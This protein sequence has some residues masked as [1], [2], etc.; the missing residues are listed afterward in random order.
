MTNAETVLLRQLKPLFVNAI[1]D[2]IVIALRRPEESLCFSQPENGQ[3]QFFP[4]R[5][6]TWQRERSRKNAY[7]SDL[8]I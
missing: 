4:H 1:I 8:L 2:R 6:A 3:S 5:K 7:F